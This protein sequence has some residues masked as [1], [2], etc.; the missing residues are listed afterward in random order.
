MSRSALAR[1]AALAV[2][3]LFPCAARA[4]PLPRFTEEREAAALHFVRKHCPDL[5]PLLDD[6]KKNCARPTNCKCAKPFR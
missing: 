5:I 4:E 6:L 1:V 3:V 2:A